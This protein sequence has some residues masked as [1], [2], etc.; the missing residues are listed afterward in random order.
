MFFPDF[1]NPVLPCAPVVGSSTRESEPPDP[2]KPALHWHEEDFH[3]DRRNFVLACSAW[4]NADVHTQVEQ[5]LLEEFWSIQLLHWSAPTILICSIPSSRHLSELVNEVYAHT[6]QQDGLQHPIWIHTIT[7][8]LQ[9]NKDKLNH[10]GA[11]Q[12]AYELNCHQMA[13][14]AQQRGYRP[15][16]PLTFS[17]FKKKRGCPHLE[18]PGFAAATHWQATLQP[19]LP[20]CMPTLLPL[21]LPPPENCVAADILEEAEMECVPEKYLEDEKSADAMISLPIAQAVELEPTPS[22]PPIPLEGRCRAFKVSCPAWT[23]DCH[24]HVEACFIHRYPELSIVHWHDSFT[25]TAKVPNHQLQ[26]LCTDCSAEGW[27]RDDQFFPLTVHVLPTVS[28]SKQRKRMQHHHLNH[29]YQLNLRERSAAH[30]PHL[31]KQQWRNQH[32]AVDS[33]GELAAP[34]PSNGAPLDITNIDGHVNVIPTVLDEDNVPGVTTELP[35]V[36]DVLAV[37][38]EVH[39]NPPAVTA[40]LPPAIIANR[41]D[42]AIVETEL[43]EV[44]TV[45]LGENCVP[46][47][48]GDKKA[49]AM[50]ETKPDE[51]KT[52]QMGENSVA[53]LGNT[54]GTD[55]SELSFGAQVYYALFGL[56]KRQAWPPPPHHTL[57]P[58]RR[59]SNHNHGC[60]LA[61]M[62]VHS[63]NHPIE[64]C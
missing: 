32:L 9:Y 16:S 61:C 53:P 21:F 43:D 45:L 12:E 46:S 1:M 30:L 23:D 35:A 54:A 38:T 2:T 48:I 37:K 57:L 26:L 64:M 58:P 60:Y 5:F 41:N 40:N 13:Y 55:R 3:G 50:D 10:Y 15:P 7:P 25:F 20:L 62:H 17:D 28:P 51:S 36:T 18:Y 49:T 33:T 22:P 42:T 11:I 14:Y 19:P 63:P 4:G 59:N 29:L 44:M 24:Q 52:V 47:A 31:T 39:I 34:L 8:D 6:W 56:P 27:V